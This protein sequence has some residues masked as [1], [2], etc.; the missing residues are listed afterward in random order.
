MGIRNSEI[1]TFI[2]PL[3]NPDHL[4]VYRSCINQAGGLGCQEQWDLGY[5]GERE[6]LWKGNWNGANKKSLHNFME[7]LWSALVKANDPNFCGGDTNLGCFF[8]W[9]SQQKPKYTLLDC[10]VP[11]RLQKNKL[12]SFSRFLTSGTLASAKLPYCEICFRPRI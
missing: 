6:T 3:I 9:K 2:G 5:P 12:L 10:P 1:I 11:L 8:P 4:T 7:G